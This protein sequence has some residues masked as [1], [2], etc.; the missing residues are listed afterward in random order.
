LNLNSDSRS[1]SHVPLTTVTQQTFKLYNELTVFLA[2]KNFV[3]KLPDNTP[4]SLITIDLS[5]N[6]LTSLAHFSSLPNLKN[7]NVSY[8]DIKSCAGLSHSTSLENINVSHNKLRI[9]EG[10][11][12]SK[13]LKMLDL[14]HNNLRGY[15]D[16]RA[17]SLNGK[18][19]VCVLEGNPVASKQGFK[20]KIIHLL[21][22]VKVV[23]NA[24]GNDLV[25]IMKKDVRGNHL[26]PKEE[27]LVLSVGL[28]QHHNHFHK[29][30]S[31]NNKTTKENT[32]KE[33]NR[34]RRSN[35]RPNPSSQY[36][37]LGTGSGI[38]Q[39]VS[40]RNKNIHSAKKLSE[41]H[42]TFG[43]KPLPWRQPPAPFPR[44]TARVGE[45]LDE[46]FSQSQASQRKKRA[47]RERFEKEQPDTNPRHH[48]QKHNAFSTMNNDDSQKNN[49]GMV[50][51]HTVWWTPSRL[52]MEP[53]FEPEP[54]RGDEVRHQHV[55][56][57]HTNDNNHQR[58]KSI[59]KR[60]MGITDRANVGYGGRHKRDTNALSNS[61]ANHNTNPFVT[62]TK[63][64]ST[65][66]NRQLTLHQQEKNKNE[67]SKYKYKV[68]LGKSL[69]GA[70]NREQSKPAIIAAPSSKSYVA[71]ESTPRQKYLYKNEEISMAPTPSS[72]FGGS[73][74]ALANR[75]MDKRR[76][77]EDILLYG[78]EIERGGSDYN[79]FSAAPPMPPQAQSNMRLQG[80]S[81]YQHQH[82]QLQQS[83]PFAIPQQEAQEH[84]PPPPEQQLKQQIRQ[85]AGGQPQIN[86]DER[87]LHVLQ[88]IVRQKQ[89]TIKNLEENAF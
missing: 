33:A 11:E 62:S 47:D 84:L 77:E 34:L 82:Q 50:G 85:D 53:T 71:T 79:P 70:T 44:M 52:N 80:N 45:V 30:N 64:K 51:E 3:E 59:H 55:V 86:L 46:A 17:I 41:E 9:V 83:H 2:S 32:T 29:S 60:S 24:A 67:A 78:S 1:R 87:L 27:A 69:N 25:E 16:I 6:D 68:S 38:T 20:F 81:Q 54:N 35:P 65:P 5:Y 88:H 26:L 31:H 42:E 43:T 18:L 15:Y 13:S 37:G 28:N 58:G 56:K 21:P 23:G 22:R 74:Y 49:I 72:L 10:L 12:R 4:K 76:R 63:P 39:L 19:E 89:E 48:R 57:Q 14:G 8:N 66:N 7:L 36:G 61:S 73:V 75:E 40:K